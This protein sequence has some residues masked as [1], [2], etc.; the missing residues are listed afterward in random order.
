MT[1]TV[2]HTADSGAL[3]SSGTAVTPLDP[4]TAAS[5]SVT[6]GNYLLVA[7]F[8]NSSTIDSAT[9]LTSSQCSSLSRINSVSNGTDG[10]N[11][12]WGGTVTTSGTLSITAT[13]TSTW[14]LAVIELHGVVSVVSGGT[15]GSTKNS[16]SMSVTPAESGDLILI[17]VGVNSNGLK[18]PY[19]GGSWTN[20]ATSGGTGTWGSSGGG[21]QSFAYQTAPSTT[22]LTAT[23]TTY[24]SGGQCA[25]VV[26]SG[27]A[28]VANTQGLL[29]SLL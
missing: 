1:I 9:A 10:D 24:G 7:V 13:T 11:E 21:D 26:V 12:W 18:S 27:G 19:P 23:W 29:V 16:P 5:I 4:A 15:T 17:M 25:G 8:V 22:A 14:S 6:S 28:G 20:Y 2:V 3:V